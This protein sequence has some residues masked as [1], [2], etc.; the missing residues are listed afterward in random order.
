ML[1]SPSRREWHNIWQYFAYLLKIKSRVLIHRPLRYIATT[2]YR[3][4]GILHTSSSPKDKI[5]TCFS[6]TCLEKDLPNESCYLLKH[7]LDHICRQLQSRS[8][9]HLSIKSSSEFVGGFLK[10]QSLSRILL[11]GQRVLL[12]ASN[13]CAPSCPSPRHRQAAAPSSAAL[14]WQVGG[15]EEDHQRTQHWLLFTARTAPRLLP[16]ADTVCT[17]L[18]LVSG[19]F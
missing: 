15:G 3:I 14:C 5:C 8:R 18:S 9:E 4:H 1:H 6:R 11:E 10:M 17:Q 16:K 13:R 7:A 12:G 2:G 19:D